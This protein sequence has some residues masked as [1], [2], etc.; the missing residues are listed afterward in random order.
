MI[1][2][3]LSLININIL[4]WCICIL[5][6]YIWVGKLGIIK[7]HYVSYCVCNRIKKDKFYKNIKNISIRNIRLGNI[8]NKLRINVYKIYNNFIKT[9]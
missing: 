7:W 6:V 3:K 2:Y 4:V 9:Q 5:E 8:L 1:L